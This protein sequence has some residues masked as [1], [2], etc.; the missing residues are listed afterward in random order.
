MYVHDATEEAYKNGYAKGYDDGKRDAVKHGHWIK[1]EDYIDQFCGEDDR[2]AKIDI[3]VCSVCGAIEID[4]Y[5][6]CHCGA[7]MDEVVKSE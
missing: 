4:K 6:Y 7:K 2:S 5:E 3:F 1:Q